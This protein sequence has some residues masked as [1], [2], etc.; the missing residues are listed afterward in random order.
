MAKDARDPLRRVTSDI[1][2]PAS[3]DRRSLHE[4]VSHV[5]SITGITSNAY[6]GIRTDLRC[7][8]ARADFRHRRVSRELEE[9]HQRVGESFEYLERLERNLRV[10]AV[11]EE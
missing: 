7:A 1:A 10:Y 11:I 2:K 9:L 6:A 4:R 8:S 5:E 3:G